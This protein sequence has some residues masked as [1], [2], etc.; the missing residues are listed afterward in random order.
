MRYGDDGALLER[1]SDGA[2]YQLI[3]L[4]VDA[5]CRFV[6]QQDARLP[7]QR[8]R[9]TQQLTL[10]DAA[11]IVTYIAESVQSANSDC[12]YNLARSQWT[13]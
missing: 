3:G 2:L 11:T 4:Q 12:K 10:S 1:C 7:E 13:K 5:R 8:S 9:Q 6:E